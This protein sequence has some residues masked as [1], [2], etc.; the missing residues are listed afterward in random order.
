MSDKNDI[1]NPK[2]KQERVI[3]INLKESSNARKFVGDNIIHHREFNAVASLIEERVNNIKNDEK[4][5]KDGTGK[6]DTITI[7]GSRGSG[8]TSFLY[9]LASECKNNKE[10]EV[11]NIIDPTMI[12][13]KGHIFLTILSQ[14]DEKV[15]DK[16]KSSDCNPYDKNYCKKKEWRELLKKLSAGLPTLDGVGGTMESWQDPE[17]IMDKGLKS[18]QSAMSLSDNFNE[19]VKK[20]LEI[21]GRKVY[22]LMLD[23]IDID[24]A[25]GWPLLET[26]RKYLTTPHIITIVTGDLRLFSKAIRKKQWK[27]FGK[28]LMKNEGEE[29]KRMGSYDK[30]VTEMESQY[31]QKVLKPQYRYKLRSMYE[32]ITMYS[33]KIDLVDIVEKEEDKSLKKYYVKILEHFGVRNSYQ[34]ESYLSFIMNLPLRTQIQF[35]TKYSNS[36]ELK[37]NVG[38]EMVD[39]FLSDF[40]EKEIDIELA[41]TLPKQLSIITLKALVENR[42]LNEAY[43]LQ[44]TTSEASL[45][46]C[47]LG[48]S[49]LFSE[50]VNKN[51]YLIFDYFTRI[52]YIRNLLSF[53]GYNHKSEAILKDDDSLIG[54]ENLIKYARLLQDKN[55]RDSMCYTTSFMR[56]FQNFNDKS[57]KE[58]N[59]PYIGSLSLYG[60]KER[61]KKEDANEK[62]DAA[63]KG[64]SQL[65]R[66]VAY[67]P[68]FMIKY[69][70]RQMTTLTYSI[71]ALLGAISEVIR[72]HTVSKDEIGKSIEQMA[73]ISTYLAPSEPS[74][75][76]KYT[77]DE[78]EDSDSNSNK[79]KEEGK[80]TG[81]EKDLSN[82]LTTWLDTNLLIVVSPHVLGKIST[83]LFYAL[84]SI[85]SLSIKEMK[86]NEMNKLGH[87]MHRRIIALMNAILIEDAREKITE[88]IGLNNDNP[89]TSGNLFIENL[90][91]INKANIDRD[92]LIFS[93]WMLSCPLFLLYI[94]KNLD[95]NLENN[96]ISFIGKNSAE[97]A[98][99]EEVLSRSICEELNSVRVK[100]EGD[101]KTE[102]AKK[103]EGTKKPVKSK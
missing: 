76:S 103:A 96:L 45:N 3:K 14:I 95:K 6:L 57:K 21:L 53:T 25:K 61:A 17:F 27:N 32:M 102:K 89:I 47:L 84:Q 20:S 81:E 60:L 12:E 35:M 83:R 18:V 79:T 78:D 88:N 90:D 39:V 94:D 29:L 68:A 74:D 59:K 13:E 56:V 9:S 19:V 63:F 92:S 73:Q 69:D 67:L 52:G 97:A 64:K 70:R 66:Q 34:Q 55:M 16:L 72:V 58:N 24:F 42:L 15:E 31:L 22:L 86:K 98:F 11:I 82:L 38:K 54:I 30:L 48:L 51:K 23:D 33:G 99:V 7:Y 91:K 5:E 10:I 50:S 75:I 26:V 44:P 41:S 28:A 40:Y 49:M 85:E 80:G 77:V 101:K 62:L 43:Q 65:A 87:A 1:P 71:Y 8:K 2:S 46:S 37:D 36:G 93:R 100:F 4:C